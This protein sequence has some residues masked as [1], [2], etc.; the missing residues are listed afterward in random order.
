M[1]RGLFLVIS[2]MHFNHF[3]PI[4][5]AMLAFG[6]FDGQTLSNIIKIQFCKLVLCL[7]WRLGRDG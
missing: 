4:N 7:W 2:H 6:G 5:S 1:R 3:M